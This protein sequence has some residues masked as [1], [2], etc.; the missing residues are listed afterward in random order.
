MGSSPTQPRKIRPPLPQSN[1][2]CGT[3]PCTK[4]SSKKEEAKQRVC[5]IPD[6]N[7][8][9]REAG[10]REPKELIWSASR[11]MG[12]VAGSTELGMA[13]I[14][15][16]KE[17]MKPRNEQ[18]KAVKADLEEAEKF[19]LNFFSPGNLEVQIL[20]DELRGIADRRIHFSHVFGASERHEENVPENGVPV[21]LAIA[22]C[23]PFEESC[24]CCFQ[25]IG[26]ANEMVSNQSMVK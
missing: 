19:L 12:P 6:S 11:V 24:C 22:L 10:K 16:N 21:V 5:Q 1:L 4:L 15:E 2:P 7:I 9:G 3:V 8:Q 13:C 18:E 14:K 25:E 26:S 20:R 17:A 23:N